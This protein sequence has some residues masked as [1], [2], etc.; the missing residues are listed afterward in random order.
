MIHM[1]P[2]NVFRMYGRWLLLL[3]CFP[4]AVAGAQDI[5]GI[6]PSKKP[7]TEQVQDKAAVQKLGQLLKNVERLHNVSF[8]IKSELLQW[9]IDAGTETFAEAGF[10][11]KLAKLLKP[12][13]L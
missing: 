10:A 12:Y 9:E 5:A 1:L 3:A 6:S 8:V 2:S 7:R 13:K 11:E 4:T